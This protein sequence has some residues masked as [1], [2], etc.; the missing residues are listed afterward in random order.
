M[1]ELSVLAQASEGYRALVWDT[2]FVSR[3]RG[4]SLEQH[5][6]WLGT[7]TAGCWYVIGQFEGEVVGGLCVRHTPGTGPAIASLGLVCV[8]PAHRGQGLS[9]ALLKRAISEAG[10]RNLAALRLWTGKPGVYQGLGFVPADKALFG[11]VMRP[12][13][14]GN[15]SGAMP[16]NEAW[17][18]NRD[19][20]FLGLPPFAR[21]GRR[22]RTSEASLLT[23]EDA[24]GTLVADWTGTSE[25]VA[26]LMEQVLPQHTRLNALEG[27]ELPAI[28]QQ[29]G[30]RCELSESRLQMVLPL[31]GDRTPL[32][33]A[34]ECTPRMLHRI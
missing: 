24:E 10:S 11:T 3:G 4:L 14:C 8:A 1:I 18:D 32:Q 12:E 26:L 7:S 34:T 2:F 22:W 20:S 16:D 17:P 19:V 29:R 27:D 9:K 30:W 28:L 23:L 21:S 33:W 13:T 31:S 15:R 5:F 25:A 6:P